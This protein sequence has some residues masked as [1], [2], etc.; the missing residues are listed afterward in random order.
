MP[1]RKQHTVAVAVQGVDELLVLHLLGV[2]QQG[3]ERFNLAGW[4]S[5]PVRS[6][7]KDQHIDVAW[8]ASQPTNPG[9]LAREMR[10]DLRWKH[11]L[12]L[13]E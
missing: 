12:D 1:L 7:G 2:K 5:L 4:R 9:E 8:R 11:M 10:H 13:T 6:Q 3:H